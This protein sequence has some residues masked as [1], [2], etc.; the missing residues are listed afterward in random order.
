MVVKVLNEFLP[1][2]EDIRIGA[3]KVGET[4]DINNDDVLDVDSSA[5]LGTYYS[6]CITEIPQDI[7]YT[8]AN[9]VLTI[10]AG[11]KAYIPDGFEEDGVTKKF[12][13]YIV[14]T[15]A[16]YPISHVTGASRLVAISDSNATY[17]YLAHYW[18]SGDTAPTIAGSVGWY[19]TANNVIK[20]S[21]SDGSSW[22]TPNVS[23]P[24]LGG[25]YTKDYGFDSIDHVFN[26]AGYVGHHA[27]ILPGVR[28]LLPDG[29]TDKGT[30]KSILIE[31][32]NIQVI[33]LTST[34]Y[35]TFDDVYLLFRPD[36]AIQLARYI[37]RLN[38]TDIQQMDG[39][40]Q[41]AYDTNLDYIWNYN[42][43]VYDSYPRLPFV[44]VSL[45]DSNVTYF[46]ILQPLRIAATNDKIDTT[47]TFLFD[48][49][50]SDHIPNKLS[51]VD[52]TTFSWQDGNVFKAAYEELLSAWNGSYISKTDNSITYRDTVRGYQIAGPDQEE[53][54]IN[55]WNSL[56][57]GWF[58]ILDIANKRFKLPRLGS[59]DVLESYKSGNNWYRLYADDWCE[60]GSICSISQDTATTVNLL[61]EMQDT[62][63]NISI[64]ARRNGATQTGGDGNFTADPINTK[65]FYW[66]N[67]D[68]FS[69]YGY[70]TVS[71]PSKFNAP[72][73]SSYGPVKRLYFY[74]GYTDI[75]ELNRTEVDIKTVTT[76]NINL[77]NTATEEGITR[78]N[79]DSNA[80]NRTQISN[81]ITEIPQNIKLE[82]NNDALTL[83]A[84]SIIYFP[85]GFE[86]DGTTPKFTTTTITDDFT[87]SINFSGTYPADVA[88]SYKEGQG[89]MYRRM[90]VEFWSGTTDSLTATSHFWYDT[91]N[92]TIK[93]TQDAGA[94]YTDGWSFPLAIVSNRA[95]KITSINTIFNGFGYIGST[96]FLLPGV[97]LLVPNGRNADGSLN[98]T[99]VT[100]SWVSTVTRTW[101]T[102]EKQSIFYNA[103]TGNINFENKYIESYY[104]PPPN[105]R[106][107]VWYNPSTNKTRVCTNDDVTWYD[108][109]MV[110]L[111]QCGCN[112]TTRICG[113]FSQRKVFESVDFSMA[114]YVIDYKAPTANDN[115]WFRLYK[116]GWI[117]QGG[118]FTNSSRLTTVTFIIPMADT[119]YTALSNLQYGSDGWTAS[120]VTC[121]AVNSRTTTNMQVLCYYNNS[122]NTGP[123]CWRIEGFMANSRNSA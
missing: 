30:V 9:G 49:K 111:F 23:L 8:L 39:Y 37:T 6:N 91:T 105:V 112:N 34:G 62:A 122:Q 3:I 109:P 46:N 81:C 108:T 35:T 28:G 80:L 87:K 65:Q 110:H 107:T 20:I 77:I 71:G 116:S 52:S 69:G 48:Y 114:D 67:G 31:T 24:L 123:I 14:T 68:D 115:R 45:N 102:N 57:A 72:T 55:A 15:D 44:N 86:S 85:D 118:M 56:H 98:N 94:T 38:Q 1:P 95:A 13:E 54:I 117:E 82:L 40:I 2:A 29:K 50:W 26:G 22:S 33:D 43:S 47:G 25:A 106:Y 53:A 89:F 101:T 5:V 10:K 74:M 19:D 41:Y 76:N 17:G 113:A 61:M 4:L 90:S 103:I 92:N 96:A 73:T 99:E 12:R 58:Y 60:Q 66:R 75:E 16:S 93:Y 79:T 64:T 7:K 70:W 32:E 18:F 27:F 97:K 100:T 51:W 42:T 21:S 119:N 36:T 104:E 83:K 63:Y 120:V 84:G 59:K 11:T 78:L 88:I 121:I